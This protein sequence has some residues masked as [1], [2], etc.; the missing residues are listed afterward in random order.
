MG[1]YGVR[2]TFPPEERDEL[3]DVV[4]SKLRYGLFNF[5]SDLG[6]YGDDQPRP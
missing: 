6:A 2:D 5:F 1:Q 4:P 3:V